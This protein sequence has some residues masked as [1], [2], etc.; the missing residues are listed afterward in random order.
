MP[1]LSVYITT[2]LLWAKVDDD[3]FRVEKVEGGWSL[4]GF[5]LNRN[6]DIELLFSW[7]KV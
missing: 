3:N 2:P 5:Y 4:S 6:D 7:D 1:W